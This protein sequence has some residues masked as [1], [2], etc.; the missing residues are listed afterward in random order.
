MPSLGLQ[1]L[2][3]LAIGV[4]ICIPVAYISYQLVERPFLRRRARTVASTPVIARP[5][6][7]R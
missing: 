4:F 5:E 3:A 6:I 2:F 1:A 7:A